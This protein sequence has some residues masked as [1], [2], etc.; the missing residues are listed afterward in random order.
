MA[1][2]ELDRLGLGDIAEYQRVEPDLRKREREG[3]VAGSGVKSAGKGFFWWAI[4]NKITLVW[5]RAIISATDLNGSSSDRWPSSSSLS[6]HRWA[7][8]PDQTKSAEDQN[9]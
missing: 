8:R 2:E 5:R 1:K 9:R 3:F 6:S 7:Q 4:V